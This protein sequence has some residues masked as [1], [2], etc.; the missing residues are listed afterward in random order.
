MDLFN[1]PPKE[2]QT[3]IDKFNEGLQSYADCVE[4][5]NELNSIGYTLDFGLDAEPYNLKKL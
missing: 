5:Q 1:N 2:T 3:V 4:L